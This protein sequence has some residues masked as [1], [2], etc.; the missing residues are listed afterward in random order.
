MTQT[1]AELLQTRHQGDLINQ[2]KLISEEFDLLP[3][4]QDVFISPF[5]DG[6]IE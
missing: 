6:G 1:K 5:F 3:K 2:A 4:S